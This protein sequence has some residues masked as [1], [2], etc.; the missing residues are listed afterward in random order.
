MPLALVYYAYGGVINM[1][2][3]WGSK[4]TEPVLRAIP[5]PERKELF[6][7]PYSKDCL[8]CQQKAKYH[9]YSYSLCERCLNKMVIERLLK[10]GH[11]Q[12]L[13]G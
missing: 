9:Y 8:F 2:N 11:E 6:L 3:L 12:S 1:K 10:E 4:D 13:S 5:D 7:V